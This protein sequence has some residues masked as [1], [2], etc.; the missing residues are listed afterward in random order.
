MKAFD[1]PVNLPMMRR[2]QNV[3]D[4]NHLYIVLERVRQV[5]DPSEMFNPERNWLLSSKG[6]PDR[7]TDLNIV[8]KLTVARRE[9]QPI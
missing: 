8:A 1:L 2:A 6:V 9:P 4:R 3:P 5:L 7:T